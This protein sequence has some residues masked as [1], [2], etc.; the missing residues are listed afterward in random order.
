[1]K[2]KWEAQRV[3]AIPH[4]LS[5]KEFQQTIAELAQ[6]MY[7][8]FSQLQKDVSKST[9]STPQTEAE[10]TGRKYA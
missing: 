1:M 10:R 8:K 2:M 7:F 9:C 5:D 4:Q 3:V 6:L